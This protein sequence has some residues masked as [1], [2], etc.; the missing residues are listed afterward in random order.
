VHKRI[1]KRKLMAKK[2]K[3]IHS[4]IK[5]CLGYG[6]EMPDKE[7]LTDWKER[8]TQVCKPCWEL[9]YC[10]YG[11]FIEQSPLLPTV[12]A[13]ALAH[14]EHIRRIL[15][16]GKIGSADPLTAEARN[17]YTKLLRRAK[18]DPR[19]L[20]PK[21]ALYLWGQEIARMAEEENK[22][23]L[24]YLAP[25]MSD[26]EKHRVPF[27]LGGKREPQGDLPEEMLAAIEAEIQRMET[28]LETGIDDQQKPLDTARRKL[29][30]KE[31]EEFDPEAYPEEIPDEV[32][33]LQCNIFGHICP[34]VFVG[35]G[36]TETTESRRRGRYI[37]FQAKMRVVRRDNYTCQSCGKHL[38]DDEVE[39]DHIIPHAKGGS[40]EEHNIRLTCFKCN[41]G[42]S[43]TV[44]I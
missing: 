33:E 13:S 3:N 15:V 41:R 2:R 30:Q 44:E 16:T 43:D 11:P 21:V 4:S 5:E 1:E 23:I 6:T 32:A 14:Q 31:V 20:A 10:P 25:P 26:F 34:V 38:R 12:R 8:S 36:I 9:K 27:P 42:K 37:S 17:E 18:K 7:F 28:A 24:E 40:C 19:I 22:S 39:F 29:F 35:E